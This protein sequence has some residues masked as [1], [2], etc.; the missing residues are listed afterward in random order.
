[1]VKKQKELYFRELIEIFSHNKKEYVRDLLDK[2]AG[3]STQDVLLLLMCEMQLDNQTMARIMGLT[4]GNPEK[5][6]DPDADKNADGFSCHFIGRIADT[7]CDGFRADIYHTLL[8]NTFFT[9]PASHLSYMAGTT[10]RSRISRR[11]DQWEKPKAVGPI[12][13]ESRDSEEIG[14]MHETGVGTDDDMGTVN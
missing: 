13:A 6:Q 11:S 7:G 4:F 1:M 2:Y 3:F 5:T 8:V 14:G 12:R 9:F 10:R